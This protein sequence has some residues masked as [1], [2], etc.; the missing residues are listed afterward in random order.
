MKASAKGP[1]ITLALFILA[2][3]ASSII[4][5]IK[6]SAQE[7]QNVRPSGDSLEGAPRLPAREFI[8]KAAALLKIGE[9]EEAE[10]LL[11]K[12]LK[13]DAR[14][15]EALKLLGKVNFL[16]KKYDA[17]EQYLHNALKVSRN[18]VAAHLLLGK[19][20]LAK[21]KKAEA[22][23][24]FQEVSERDP[25]N[26]ESRLLLGY[27]RDDKSLL[28]PKSANL[29]DLAYST[30]ITRGE[31][32]NLLINEV[33]QIRALGKS[34]GAAILSDIAGAGVAQAAQA[35]VE[36]GIMPP[37]PNLTFAPYATL[38]R[39]EMALAIEAVLARAGVKTEELRPGR[40]SAGDYGADEFNVYH[41]A[42]VLLSSLGLI[43]PSGGP[44]G[45][46]I[47]GAVSGQ[48]A[49]SAL[50]RLDQYLLS[51]GMSDR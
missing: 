45:D 31:L 4:A 18:D 37:Y 11:S 19:V 8:L 32:A 41:K 1:I 25:Q 10:D 38:M 34:V 27:L 22:F 30:A 36:R 21:K 35:V 33:P 5:G 48:E 9:I 49:L 2:L 20:K 47:T 24:H 6:A 28:K 14:N 16:I 17:A 13:V 44:G 29:A 15:G 12:A 39:G 43:A 23:E 3:C 7:P 26:S 50:K 40:A 42:T 46:L 51:K